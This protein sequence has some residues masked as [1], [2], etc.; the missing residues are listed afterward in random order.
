MSRKYEIT[1]S[2]YMFGG[3][4]EGVQLRDVAVL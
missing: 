4:R 1:H 3:L 2:A